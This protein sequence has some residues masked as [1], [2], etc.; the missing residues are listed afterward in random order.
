MGFK[1]PLVRI[2]SL[3]PKSA[4]ILEFSKFLSTFLFY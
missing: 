3:G 1:R 4:E 2:Q